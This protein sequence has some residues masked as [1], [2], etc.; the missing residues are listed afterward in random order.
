[1]RNHEANSTFY[2]GGDRQNG[3]ISPAGYPDEELDAYSCCHSGADK[4]NHQSST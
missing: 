2:Q 3:G 4:V 1:M